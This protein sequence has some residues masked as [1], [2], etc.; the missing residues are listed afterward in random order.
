[1]GKKIPAF[2]GLPLGEGNPPNSAWGLWG[3]KSDLGTLNWL[4]E[5]NVLEAVKEIRTG[6]RVGLECASSFLRMKSALLTVL[7]LSA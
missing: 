1:M 5:A 7:Q 2:S 6:Q 3:E 4:D